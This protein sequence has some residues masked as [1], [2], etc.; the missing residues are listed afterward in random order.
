MGIVKLSDKDKY[1]YQ[2]I[3]EEP[4]PFHPFQSDTKSLATQVRKSFHT[5]MHFTVRFD[6]L[7]IPPRRCKGALKGA[8]R[9]RAQIPLDFY[10][11]FCL[12]I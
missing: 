8:K 9:R 12:K 11:H 4:F 5:I 10:E 6:S 2:S 1:L 7:V 3:T